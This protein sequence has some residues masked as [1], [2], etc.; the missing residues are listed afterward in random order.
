[1]HYFVMLSFYF[2]LIVCN[3]LIIL[4]FSEI[5]MLAIYSF[6]VYFDNCLLSRLEKNIDASS[7]NVI[8]TISLFVIPR[9]I[10]IKRKITTQYL[11][12]FVIVSYFVKISSIIIGIYTTFMISF[13]ILC[14][15][16]MLLSKSKMKILQ[17]NI[18]K[19]HET[20]KNHI[21]GTK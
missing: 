7:I 8:D 17:K 3:D 6:F 2:P 13:F 1:M 12:R 11:F 18:Y 10:I 19:D 5:C 20:N 4:S 16:H 15:F 14:S 21:N 9:N